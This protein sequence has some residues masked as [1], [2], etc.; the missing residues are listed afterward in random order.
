MVLCGFD[1]TVEYTEGGGQEK[2]SAR[3]GKCPCAV[4][5]FEL[6]GIVI[7]RSGFFLIF[8]FGV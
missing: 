4:S 5:P 3:R 7:V 1:G 6:L 2:G 8:K